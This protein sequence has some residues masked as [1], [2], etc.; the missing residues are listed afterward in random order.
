M[1]GTQPFHYHSP[2]DHSP[3]Y[4]PKLEPNFFR[5]FSFCGQTLPSLH[6]LLQHYE[7]L[8]A[9][10]LQNGQLNLPQNISKDS[11]NNSI[12]SP[13]SLSG[14]LGNALRTQQMHQQRLAQ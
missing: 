7:E 11:R 1:T 6:H 9:Q 14:G 10:Q 4:L 13:T 12:T 8:H 3:P 5:A 2:P